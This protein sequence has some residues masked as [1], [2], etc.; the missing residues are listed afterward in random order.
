MFRPGT[1]ADAHLAQNERKAEERAVFLTGTP[2]AV[3]V[4]RAALDLATGLLAG[5]LI[6]A[7]ANGLFLRHVPGRSDNHALEE[8][9]KLLV[10]GRAV[11]QV[12]AGEVLQ[13]RSACAPEVASYLW[14]VK[15]KRRPRLRM[16]RFS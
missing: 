5:S 11:E 1:Q 2:G 8:Q 15:A 6:E 14:R 4:A 7:H 12:E 10:A 13:R 9:I 16:S 3:A